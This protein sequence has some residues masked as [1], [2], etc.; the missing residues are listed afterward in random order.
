[1]SLEYPFHE[2]S[3]NGGPTVVAQW[4]T[5][6]CAS[7]EFHFYVVSGSGHFHIECIDCE[8][9]YCPT[10]VCTPT[11][12]NGRDPVHFDTNGWY[13]WDETWTNRAGP[14]STEEAARENVSA[15]VRWLNEGKPT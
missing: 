12:D 4:G 5:C 11:K 8:T 14:F 2:I 1:M 9:A 13:H 3:E 6:T 10:G 15:Y 7:E